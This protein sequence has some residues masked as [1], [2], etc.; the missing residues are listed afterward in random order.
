M[1]YV[2]SFDRM[3]DI[4]E[5]VEELYEFDDAKMGE[6]CKVSDQLVKEGHAVIKGHSYVFVGSDLF[7]KKTTW[8]QKFVS[9]LS[10]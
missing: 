9:W 7:E 3:K 10:L 5:F 6:I 1:T 2:T 8:I 4:L